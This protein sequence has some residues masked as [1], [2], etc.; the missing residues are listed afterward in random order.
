M[1]S[2][3]KG[4]EEL[5]CHTGC[6]ALFLPAFPSQRDHRQHSYT[7]ISFT[8]GFWVRSWSAISLA[9]QA[10]IPDIPTLDMTF[11]ISDILGLAPVSQPLLG[12]QLLSL[13]R[14]SSGDTVSRLFSIL[15]PFRVALKTGDH[16]FG[17]SLG[18]PSQSYSTS[19][20]LPRLQC[21]AEEWERKIPGGNSH[22]NYSPH[23]YQPPPIIQDRKGNC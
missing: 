6:P 17:G 3:K 8:V 13:P 22:E 12:F 10:Y 7:T 15:F 16:Y 14:I 5:R 19:A 9:L 11:S 2:S 1:P 20:P 21:W 23:N 4:K 18:A